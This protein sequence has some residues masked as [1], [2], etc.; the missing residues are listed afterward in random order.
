MTSELRKQIFD[1]MQKCCETR[2]R[3]LENITH[4]KNLMAALNNFY[5]PCPRADALITLETATVTEK[6]VRFFINCLDAVL[7]LYTFQ[8]ASIFMN[9]LGHFPIE[10]PPCNSLSDQ[11]R[12]LFC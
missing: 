7:Y 1:A 9:N 6:E 2:S 10:F 5:L 11:A 3:V 4:T 8:I 12:R